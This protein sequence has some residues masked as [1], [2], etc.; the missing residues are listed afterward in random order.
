MKFA[1]LCLGLTAVVLAA[2][3]T[4]IQAKDETIIPPTAPLGSFSHVVIK[5]L[6]TDHSDSDSG[7][8]KAIAK[9]DRELAVCLKDVFKDG[10]LPTDAKP[11]PGTL[12]IEPRIEDISKKTVTERIFLGPLTGSS[13]VLLKVTY[14]AADE[15]QV[16]AKPEFFAKAN[17]WGGAFTFGTTDNLIMSRVVSN[18]CDYA[19]KYH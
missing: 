15:N 19:R 1:P 3:S 18:A 17:S 13:A 4:N 12:V 7:D 9:I 8:R 5:P 11:L 2:C 14:R 16:V 10:E 6:S